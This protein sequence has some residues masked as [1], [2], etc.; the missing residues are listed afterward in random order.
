MLKQLCAV[1]HIP[2]THL[3]VRI[4]V[5]SR[6]C[7]PSPQPFIHHPPRQ[8]RI[9]S[10]PSPPPRPPQVQKPQAIANLSVPVY[11]SVTDISYKWSPD[12]RSFVICFLAYCFE[13]S[14]ISQLFFLLLNNLLC[15]QTTFIHLSVN[16]HL[17][18]FYLLAFRNET[19]KNIHHVQVFVD[20]CFHF[21]RASMEEWNCRMPWQLS[22]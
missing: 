18:W 6:S 8:T 19:D 1:T 14:S 20:V 16:G 17:D 11:L 2:F 12:M 21:S 4:S 5:Y 9:Q 13:G 10:Y 15:G 22:V 3:S 7:A